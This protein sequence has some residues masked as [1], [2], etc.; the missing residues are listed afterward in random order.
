MPQ[1]KEVPGAKVGADANGNIFWDKKGVLLMDYLQQGS[2]INAK[3]YRVLLMKL[4]QNIKE[5]C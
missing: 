1:A 3:Y 4:R 2:T 5:K